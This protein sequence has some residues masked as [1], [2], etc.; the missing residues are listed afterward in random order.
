MTSRDDLARWLEETSWCNEPDPY[1]WGDAVRYA[2]GKPIGFD[3]AW[4]DTIPDRLTEEQA[5]A[6]VEALYHQLPAFRQFCDDL[7]GVVRELVEGF[8]RVMAVMGQ[9]PSAY[10]PQHAQHAHPRDGRRCPTHGTALQAGPC[11]RCQREQARTAS[12]RTR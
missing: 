6:V 4:D 1:P 12:R 8:A 11:R 5:Q 7:L 3:G 2:D 9:A 10:E